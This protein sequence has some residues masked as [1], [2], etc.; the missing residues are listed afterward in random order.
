LQLFTLH[1]LALCTQVSI[2]THLTV[3]FSLC[4]LF[5]HTSQPVKKP[6]TARAIKR[7]EAPLTSP[8]LS[9]LT[10]AFVGQAMEKQTQ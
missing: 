9:L 3:A 1:V 6:E 2:E 8:P 4:L 10:M 7:F 5:Y